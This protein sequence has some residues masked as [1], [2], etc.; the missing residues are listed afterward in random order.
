[1]QKLEQVIKSYGYNT[2]I[3]HDGVGILLGGVEV[4]FINTIAKTITVENVPIRLVGQIVQ[5][6]NSL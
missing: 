2:K 1:M 3:Y 4:G 6:L 5:L